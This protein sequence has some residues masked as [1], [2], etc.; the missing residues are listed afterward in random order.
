MEVYQERMQ[1]AGT[2]NRSCRSTPPPD[3]QIVR[4]VLCTLADTNSNLIRL[5]SVLHIPVPALPQPLSSPLPAHSLAW[6]V[7]SM[8][9]RYAMDGLSP[10]YMSRDLGHYIWRL[11]TYNK[12]TYW[13]DNTVH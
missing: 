7:C 2:R 11:A 5:K 3:D 4:H 10:L 6:P 12:P 13:T 9:Q 1:D 8:S